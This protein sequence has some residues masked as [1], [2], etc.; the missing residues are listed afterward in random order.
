[1]GE[2]SSGGGRGAQRARG[3]SPERFPPVERE[4][5]LERALIR[6]R[7]RID[8]LDRKIAALLVRR[9]DEVVKAGGIKRLLGLTVADT[10]REEEILARI[11]GYGR[12]GGGSDYVEEVYRAIFRC[13]RAVEEKD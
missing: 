4:P 5:G 7:G 6:V 2:R 9:R 3:S 1:M 10:R 13:S 11:R 8:R 12:G